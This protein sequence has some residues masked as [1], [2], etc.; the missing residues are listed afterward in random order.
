MMI[1]TRKRLTP[2]H[3]VRMQLAMQLAP[4]SLTDLVAASGLSKPVV[5]RFVRDLQASQLAHVG[6]WGR[7]ARGYPTIEKYSFGAGADLACPRKNETSTV[8]MAALRAK[9]KAA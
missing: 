3:T 8:R 4:Q 1:A 9:R 7:D 5:T 2:S 6:D